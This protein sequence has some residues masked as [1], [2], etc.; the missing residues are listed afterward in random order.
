MSDYTRRTT[1]LSARLPSEAEA[2]LLSQAPSRPMLQAEAVNIDPDGRPIQ[3]SITRFA[4]DRVQML[5]EPDGA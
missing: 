4:G 5:I 2:R 3:Y 1:R